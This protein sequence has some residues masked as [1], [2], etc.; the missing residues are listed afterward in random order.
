LPPDYGELLCNAFVYKN[1]TLFGASDASLKEGRA[2]HAWILSSGDIN[3]IDNPL[4]N[5]LGAGP[6]HGIPH[7]L[8][9]AREELQG[10]TALTIKVRLFME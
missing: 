10:I 7:F 3:Y 4:M 1:K 9:S 6:A 5:I 2:T 8:S